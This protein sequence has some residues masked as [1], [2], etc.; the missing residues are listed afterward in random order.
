[1][2]RARGDVAPN[3]RCDCAVAAADH[4]A[5]ANHS[6]HRDLAGSDSRDGMTLSGRCE[7]AASKLSLRLKYRVPFLAG[8][9]DFPG[10]LK[11]GRDDEGVSR[12]ELMSLAGH[13]FEPHAPVD[14]HTQLMF[15]VAH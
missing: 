3:G 11:A 8:L 14:Q 2:L 6:D 4:R 15:G 5:K 13:R 12:A 10:P 9:G 1:M 7:R